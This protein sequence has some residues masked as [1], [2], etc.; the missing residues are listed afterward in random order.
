MYWPW[1]STRWMRASISRL[2]TRYCA[3]RS[4]N[5]IAL[6][7]LPQLFDFLL[8]GFVLRVLALQVAGGRA[9]LLARPLGRQ[10]VRVC[11]LVVAVPEVAHLDQAPV[12]QRA[13]A[14]VDLAHAHPQLAGQLAL[15]QL[16]GLLQQAQQLEA[17]GFV[18]QGDLFG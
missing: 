1:S 14:E 6:Y 12:E 2:S 7:L 18:E 10:V 13:Q 15:G 11:E 3:F 17:G 5:S 16:R 8:D 4:V 9:H